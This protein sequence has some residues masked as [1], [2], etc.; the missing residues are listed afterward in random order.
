MI[1][2]STTMGKN[3]LEEM[4][5]TSQSTKESETQ[6]LDT[7]SKMAELFQFPFQ[8]KPFNITVIQVYDLTT[9]SKEAEVDRFYEDLQQLLEPSPPQKKNVR[10]IRGG[11]NAKA[12]SQEISGITGKFGLDL[13]NEA[14]QS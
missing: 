13:Q 14:G 11:C 5:Q 7:T 9:K 3:P 8:D 2:K 10:F 4:E 12:G 6:Y 1:I